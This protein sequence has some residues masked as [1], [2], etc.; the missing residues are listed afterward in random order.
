[1]DRNLVLHVFGRPAI[2]A[3]NGRDVPGGD[4]AARELLRTQ[5]APATESVLI[6][7]RGGRLR[8][9]LA[10]RF[11]LRATTTNTCKRSFH[12]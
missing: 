3:S 11:V 12:W 8:H 10:H 2:R 9:A 1:M 5:S 7:G 4:A 6:C